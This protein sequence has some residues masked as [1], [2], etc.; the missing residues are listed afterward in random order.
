MSTFATSLVCLF[1]MLSG[2]ADALPDTLATFPKISGAITEIK[3]GELCTAVRI[4]LDDD[5]DPKVARKIHSALKRKTYYPFKSFRQP[6]RNEALLLFTGKELEAFK[7][8]DRIVIHGYSIIADLEASR[9]G[10]PRCNKIEK[11]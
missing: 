7:V 3:K 8:G 1:L 6:G 5:T 11:K 2:A 9:R 10:W 4:E